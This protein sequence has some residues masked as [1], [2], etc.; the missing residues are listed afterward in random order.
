[1]KVVS[2]AQMREL[3][4]QAIDVYGIPGDV[5]MERAG[6]GVAR[7]VL[8]LLRSS[9]VPGAGVRLVA[10][11]GNN[12]GDAFVA[13]RCLRREGVDA[14]LWMTGDPGE[15]GRDA[16]HHWDRMLEAGI[17]P[18]V[19]KDEEAWSHVPP[20]E[21][22]AIIVDGVLGTGVSGEIRGVAATAIDRIIAWSDVW[23]C[24]ERTSATRCGGSCGIAGSCGYWYSA[25]A[26]A[27]V[28]L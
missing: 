22:G 28:S 7:V 12:G 21:A 6:A 20:P 1:M 25:C 26:I 4:R 2:A 23:I 13:A 24:E 15:L 10:G 8:S 19:M 18:R 9:S 16:R 5:L 14:Q 27:V 3:D 11:K 17:E